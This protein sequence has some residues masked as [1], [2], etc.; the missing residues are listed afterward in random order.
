MSRPSWDSPYSSNRS[1]SSSSL[2]NNNNNNSNSNTSN[3]GGSGGTPVPSADSIRK[4]IRS[5][6]VDVDTK[7]SHLSTLND[8]VLR[9]NSNSTSEV[10][11][12]RIEFD[13]L[14]EDLENIFKKLKQG[15]ES[16]Q[17]EPNISSSM[18]Q[19]H[20]DKLED[21]S[22]EYWKFKKSI[23]FALESAELLS[24]STYNK[25]GDVEIP[26]GNLI[27]EQGSLQSS[28][29]VADSILGQARQAHEALE[30]QRRIL[31]GTN[32]KINQMPN[33]FQ[34]VD[35]VMSKIK[36]MKNRNLVV[37]GTLIGLFLKINNINIYVQINIF[38]K[39]EEFLH[40]FV[41]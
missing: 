35:G 37:L 24:G 31:R 34:T 11:D 14:I 5:L 2:L 36:R 28:H 26:M 32:H 9:E 4:E 13:M 7:L 19:H 3:G 29:S 39:R 15:N 8:K 21:F 30:N 27:R 23:N 33:L 16:L 25:K 12:C 40:C 1:S 10:E 20:R 38:Q 18:L 6:E 41:T 17:R 22:K